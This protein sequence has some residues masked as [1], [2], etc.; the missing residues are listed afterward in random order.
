MKGATIG[1]F[2]GGIPVTQNKETLKKAVPNIVVGTPGRIK[3]VRPWGR[4]ARNA[5]SRHA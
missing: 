4:S 2:Y 3:Q 5:G 1:N